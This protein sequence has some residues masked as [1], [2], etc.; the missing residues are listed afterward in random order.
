[1]RRHV[2]AV[3]GDTICISIHALQAECDPLRSGRLINH[4]LISIHALQA[5]CDQSPTLLLSTAT[6]SIHALQAE[7]DL[8]D[9][10]SIRQLSIFLSTH[11]KRS[12]TL[13]LA[14]LVVYHNNFYP[15]T[16]SGVRQLNKKYAYLRFFRV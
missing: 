10:M 14:L 2:T 12:A 9:L 1:M 8:I 5:E 16:P 15:R 11:S 13:Q 7:C 3:D 6:I 4:N